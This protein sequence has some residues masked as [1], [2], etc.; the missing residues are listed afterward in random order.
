VRAPS[1][2]I[3]KNALDLN[4]GERIDVEFGSGRAQADIVR[5]ESPL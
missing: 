4:I 5:I 1:G 2:N 3:V